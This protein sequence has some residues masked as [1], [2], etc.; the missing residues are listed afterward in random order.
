[1]AQSRQLTAAAAIAAGAAAAGAAALMGARRIALRRLRAGQ[2][3]AAGEPLG[4]LSGRPLTV[5]ATDGLALHAEISGPDDAPVTIIFSHGYTLNMDVFHYQHAL[6]G[7]YR[8]VCWDQRSHG[9]SGRSDPARV[10]ISQLGEDLR[11]VLLATSPGAAPV[12]LAGHSMGGMTVLALAR[13]HPELF[14][15]RVAG[16]ALLSPVAAA[17]VP[18]GWLPPPLRPVARLAARAGLRRAAAGR[19]RT[20]AGLIRAAGADL[21][22]LGTR[23]TAFGDPRVSPLVVDY[24]ERIIRATPLDVLAQFCLAMLEHDELP[25]VGVLG[26]I[27]VLVLAGGRDRMVAPRRSAELAAAMPGAELVSVPAAGHAVILECPDI[28]NAA[29]ASLAGR[30]AAAATPCGSGQ[31]AR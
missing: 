27:P 26:R 22:F 7:S 9:R 20:L 13:L 25:A 18:V 30:L 12:L 6:A 14:G 5:L 24:L 31:P 17:A 21:A 19:G 29:I 3:P 2:D 11:S 8:L 4:Q 1:M 15:A 10:T 23:W 28:V 16:A